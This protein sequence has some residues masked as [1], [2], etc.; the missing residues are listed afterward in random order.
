MGTNGRTDGRTD[1]RTECGILGVGWDKLGHLDLHV[2]N[3]KIGRSKEL[4]NHGQH[5][6]E[7]APLDQRDLKTRIN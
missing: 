3:C 2:N 7:G 1:E 4:P 5:S 6:A